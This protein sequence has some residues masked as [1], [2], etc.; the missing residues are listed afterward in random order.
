[1]QMQLNLRKGASLAKRLNEPAKL[2][3]ESSPMR[4]FA[5]LG[6]KRHL[7]LEPAAAWRLCIAFGSK[8]ADAGGIVKPGVE[9]SGTPGKVQNKSKAR[10]AGDSC[11]SREN[12]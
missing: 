2:A 7:I 12:G 4:G 10:G 8:P 11:R 3:E 5:S 6:L 1:M 9:R